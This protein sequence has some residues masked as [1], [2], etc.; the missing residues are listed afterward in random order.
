MTRDEILEDIRMVLL[1][2]ERHADASGNTEL[3]QR[4]FDAQ[5]RL[6]VIQDDLKI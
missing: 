3:G 5:R 2:C 4:A 6:R 1:D